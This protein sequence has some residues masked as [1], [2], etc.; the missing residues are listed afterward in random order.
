MAS[1]T[2]SRR[3]APPIIEQIDNGNWLAQEEAAALRDEL[4]YQRAIH[5]YML[6]Q[7]AM[8]VVVKVE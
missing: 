6:M 5:A 7:P 2:L 8:N 4:F 3:S 1:N